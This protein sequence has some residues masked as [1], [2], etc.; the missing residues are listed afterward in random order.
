MRVC[1][2][3]HIRKIANQNDWM[4]G[5]VG[6]QLAKD[7]HNYL[8]YFRRVVYLAKITECLMTFREYWDD[9]R[10]QNRLDRVYKPRDDGPL[11]SASSGNRYISEPWN[12]HRDRQTQRCKDLAYDRV[13]IS[14]HFFYFGQQARQLDPRYTHYIAKGRYRQDKLNGVALWN[15]SCGLIRLYQYA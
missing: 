1:E 6:A 15:L 14:S 7:H 11:V 5:T 3:Y 13:L 8:R 12:C 9:S 4:M 10:F 2:G